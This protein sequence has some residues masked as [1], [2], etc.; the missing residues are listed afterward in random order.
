MVVL[1]GATPIGES[2]TDERA[3]RFPF[4]LSVD[5]ILRGHNWDPKYR[6]PLTEIGVNV[7][8]GDL[9]LAVA[10]FIFNMMR[11]GS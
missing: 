5:R 8:V 3:P 7:R 10:S 6:S 2:L 11:G 9:I 4:L 1:D